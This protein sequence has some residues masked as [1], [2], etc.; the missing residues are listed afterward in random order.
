MTC[1][2]K[3]V[4]LWY[5]SKCSESFQKCYEGLMEEIMPLCIQEDVYLKASANLSLCT[6]CCQIS[7]YACK[8]LENQLLLCT[9]KSLT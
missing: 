7:I 3:Q 5:G 8:A 6:Q 1:D 4:F 9:V 2:Y